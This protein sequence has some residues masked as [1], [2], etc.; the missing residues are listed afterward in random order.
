MRSKFPSS[1]SIITTQKSCDWWAAR[2]FD[3]RVCPGRVSLLPSLSRISVFVINL[4]LERVPPSSPHPAKPSLPLS[5][6]L[7][8]S[9]QNQGCRVLSLAHRAQRVLAFSRS[10]SMSE[11]SLNVNLK[12]SELR[13]KFTNILLFQHGKW[14]DYRDFESNKDYVAWLGRLAGNCWLQLSGSIVLKWLKDAV[15]IKIIKQLKMFTF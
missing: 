12:G 13:F 6:S 14:M 4:P 3:R 10:I 15:F 11:E 9:I 1:G 2:G 8:P 5:L 7:P